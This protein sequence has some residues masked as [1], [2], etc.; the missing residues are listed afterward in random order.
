MTFTTERYNS[1]FHAKLPNDFSPNHGVLYL[2]GTSWIVQKVNRE[3]GIRNMI[4]CD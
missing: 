1:H 2:C 4:D 3:Y